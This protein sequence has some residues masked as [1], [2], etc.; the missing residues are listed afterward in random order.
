ME[1]KIASVIRT[2]QELEI[3][4]TYGNLS[5]LLGCIQ[6]LAEILDKGREEGDSDV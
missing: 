1:D 3:K 6:T 5:K 4:A 2:L